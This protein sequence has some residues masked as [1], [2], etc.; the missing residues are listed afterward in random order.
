MVYHWL[1]PLGGE[2]IDPMAQ[3]IATWAYLC[4]AILAAAFIAFLVVL[5]GMTF[6]VGCCCVGL[7]GGVLF[8]W[9]RY[10]LTRANATAPPTIVTTTPIIGGGRMKT[11]ACQNKRKNEPTTPH[12]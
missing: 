11:K 2:V 3:R 5:G 10:S 1:H 6:V 4:L 12:H 8:D 7:L 9:V